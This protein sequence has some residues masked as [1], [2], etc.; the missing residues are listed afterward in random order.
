[1]EGT[2]V[3][4]YACDS[5]YLQS[6]I[7][8]FEGKPKDDVAIRLMDS[9]KQ[10]DSD[11]VVFNWECCGGYGSESFPEGNEKVFKF[12]RKMMDRGFMCMFSDFSLKALVKNWDEKYELGPNPFAK[13][14][15]YSAVF[16]IRFNN[17]ELKE[18]PS[19]QLQI[20]GDM[21]V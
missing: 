10:V 20:V 16:E 7:E 3:E 19:A 14:G 12:L 9:I 2:K 4:V 11:C 18:C 21:A 17:N 1:M 8:A 13:T 5:H 6:L 15:E